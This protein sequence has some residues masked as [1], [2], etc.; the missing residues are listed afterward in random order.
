MVVTTLCAQTES[1]EFCNCFDAFFKRAVTWMPKTHSFPFLHTAHSILTVSPLS[2]FLCCTK[3]LVIIIVLQR[4]HT[5]LYS[6]SPQPAD[7]ILAMVKS[8]LVHFGI[9]PPPPPFF[10]AFLLLIL[11]VYPNPSKKCIWNTCILFILLTLMCLIL[12]SSRIYLIL[13]WSLTYYLQ[14]IN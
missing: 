6:T 5:V 14:L 8:C 1:L 11:D 4:P 7:R 2:R 12:L 10:F 9:T 3:I 13:P